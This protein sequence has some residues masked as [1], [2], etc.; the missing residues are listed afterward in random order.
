MATLLQLRLH[1]LEVALQVVYV[2]NAL[3]VLLLVGGE[4]RL[5]LLRLLSLRVQLALQL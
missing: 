3:R 5:E 2:L 4:A 1:E